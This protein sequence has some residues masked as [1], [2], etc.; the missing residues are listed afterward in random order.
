MSKPCPK[1][2]KNCYA[3]ALNK[4]AENG[5]VMSMD[6]CPKCDAHLAPSGICLNACH[7]SDESRAKFN[8]L[9]EL[10]AKGGRAKS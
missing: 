6:I 1:H 9:M 7:L 4:V 5:P 3:V 8:R 10:C 2:G